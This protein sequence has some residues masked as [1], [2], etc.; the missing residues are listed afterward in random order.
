MATTTNLPNGNLSTWYYAVKW[1]IYHI[2]QSIERSKQAGFKATYDEH[3]L[4]Q[5]EDL[6]QFL[7]MSWDKWM[8]DLVAGQTEEEPIYGV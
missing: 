2:E 5:L 4:R 6:E 7:K 8:D 1:G 3:Q